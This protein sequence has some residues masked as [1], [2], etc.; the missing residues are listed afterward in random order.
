M[1][2]A[3]SRPIPAVLDCRSKTEKPDPA[4]LMIGDR[5]AFVRSVPAAT[6]RRCRANASGVVACF[7]R[8]SGGPRL[9]RGS[10]SEEEPVCDPCQGYDG[11]TLGPVITKLEM[12][13]WRSACWACPRAADRCWGEILN[14]ARDRRGVISPFH[15]SLVSLTAAAL[16]ALPGGRSER[17]DW[18][19]RVP[20]D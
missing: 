16:G 10:L 9:P 20:A 11:H 5:P 4:I 13:A 12:P 1:L 15:P 19:S 6:I 3:T 18:S 14:F 8:A 7:R 2:S 17:R